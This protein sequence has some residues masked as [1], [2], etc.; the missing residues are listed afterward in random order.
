MRLKLEEANETIRQLRL[1]VERL[2]HDKEHA[3]CLVEDRDIEIKRLRAKREDQP[4]QLTN[5]LN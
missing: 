5:F 4:H 1:T 3:I 2:T